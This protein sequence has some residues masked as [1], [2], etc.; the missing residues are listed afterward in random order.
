MKYLFCVPH[1]LD[2]RTHGF[3]PWYLGSSPSPAE[4]ELKAP[5]CAFSRAAELGAA[6]RKKALRGSKP[7]PTILKNER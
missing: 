5:L 3:G 7:L 6:F 1:S 2:C 4:R